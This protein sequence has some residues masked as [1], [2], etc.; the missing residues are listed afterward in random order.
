MVEFGGVDDVFYN[1]RHPYTHGL[2]SSLPKLDREEET[3]FSIEGAPPSLIARPSGCSF[4][5]RCTHAVARCSTEEPVLRPV[6]KVLS[7]CH[8][9][10]NLRKDKSAPVADTNPLDY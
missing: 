10:E 7:A 2:L 4:H 8:L 6:D 9:A 1:S 5:P 3:L